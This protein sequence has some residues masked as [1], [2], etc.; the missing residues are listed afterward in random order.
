[1]ITRRFSNRRQRG[2]CAALLACVACDAQRT[3]VSQQ[4]LVFPGAVAV[5]ELPGAPIAQVTDVSKHPEGILLLDGPNSR[6]LVIGFDG[7][8]RRSFGRHG[9]APG[10]F[11]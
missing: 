7:V 8:V 4:P 10:E 11:I 2:L 3:K 5:G 6:V 1:M 9:S